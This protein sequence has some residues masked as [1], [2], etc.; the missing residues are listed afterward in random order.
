MTTTNTDQGSSDEVSSSSP[1]NRTVTTGGSA[2]VAA[3]GFRRELQQMLQGWEAVMSANPALTSS[4]GT[5]TQASVLGQL[6]AYLAT[7]KAMDTHAMALQHMRL[8]SRDELAEAEKYFAALRSA[9]RSFFGEESPQLA[10]FG[11]K[12]K[13]AAAPLTSEARAVRVAKARA[14]RTLRG[15]KGHLQLQKIKSG[16]MLFM[17]PVL[18]SPEVDPPNAPAASPPPASK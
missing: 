2:V 14:T 10:H 18:D 11:L 16:P 3:K 5:L 8:R 1:T 6:Q 17:K 13:K 12:P 4:V 15:T 7:Y 9:L